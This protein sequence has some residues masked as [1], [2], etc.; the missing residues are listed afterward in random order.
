MGDYPQVREKVTRTIQVAIP[1]PCDRKTFYLWEH[2]IGQVFEQHMG[3]KAEWDD[4]F[5]ITADGT[6]MVASFDSATIAPIV[7]APGGGA[8]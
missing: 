5:V 2:R 4:D 3:R 1:L 6:E 8:Q 7:A